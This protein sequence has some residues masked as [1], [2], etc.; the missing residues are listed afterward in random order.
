MK[1]IFISIITLIS[2]LEQGHCQNY[3]I[4]KTTTVNDIDVRI[5]KKTISCDSL[6]YH[7]DIYYD[8]NGIENDSILIKATLS[9]EIKKLI[10]SNLCKHITKEQ[11]WYKYLNFS[12][13]FDIKGKYGIRIISSNFEGYT[14]NELKEIIFK[15]INNIN[16]FNSNECPGL[17]EYFYYSYYYCF[18]PREKK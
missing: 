3:P 11:C 15:A 2:V 14:S 17:V 12:F 7:R 8:E 1:L 4:F 18:I 13:I 5:Y 9:K 6:S 10:E 16:N